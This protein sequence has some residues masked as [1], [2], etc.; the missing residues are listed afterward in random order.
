LFYF[1][2]NKRKEEEDRGEKVYFVAA[3]EGKGGEEEGENSGK[4]PFPCF[5]RR[6]CGRRCRKER[7]EGEKKEKERGSKAI[8]I[9]HP[10]G[11][12]RR[13]KGGEGGEKES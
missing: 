5:A 9:F 8:I 6:N 7:R 2:G 1:K 13:E 11:Q 4:P 3:N 12:R 10:E